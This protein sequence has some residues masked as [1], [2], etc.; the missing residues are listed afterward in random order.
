MLRFVAH[1]AAAEGLE[2][3]RV[4]VNVGGKARDGATGTC[5][6]AFDKVIAAILDAFRGQAMNVLTGPQARNI[7]RAQKFGGRPTGLPP[8][9][10]NLKPASL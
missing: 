9:A 4:I 5:V 8:D 7:G 2:D 1:V 10:L 6:A 3:Y